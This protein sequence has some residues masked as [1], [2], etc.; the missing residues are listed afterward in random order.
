MN[1]GH[2][3]IA[4]DKFKGSLTAP[5]VAGHLAAGLARA[6]PT[7]SHGP[8]LRLVPVADGGDGTLEAAL[9]AGFRSVPVPC[10][11]PTGQPIESSYAER[12]GVAVVELADASGLRRLP[13]GVRAPMRASS[14]GTGE[15]VRAAL[16]AGC[17]EIVLGLGGSACTDGGAGML[18]ALGLRLTDGHGADPGPGGEGLLEVA[19]VDTSGLHPGVHGARIVVACDVDNPL[20]GPHG[21]AQVYGRQKGADRVLAGELDRALARWAEVLHRDAGIADGSAEIPGA[22]AAGGVGF[23]ALTVLGASVR[24]GI[25]YLLD[26]VGFHSALAGAG[27]VIT[28]EGSVDRQTLRG[29]AP[30]GVAK[31]ARRAGV[32][33]LAVAG[34]C[35]ITGTELVDAGFAGAYALTDLEPDPDRCVA[36]AGALL[37]RL[38]AER[39]ARDPLMPPAPAPDGR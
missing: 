5:Q 17:R 6:L 30:A 20:L 13:G 15:L 7:E 35:L 14:Y 33:V 26:L 25:E 38:A 9:A 2:V 12:D 22:G 8:D 18:R 37:E 23:A 36:E 32:D 4:P 27:L 21:A 19:S 16:D 10:T 31:A 29:K 34:R 3:L 1:T 28:G 39:L 24:P 11:G